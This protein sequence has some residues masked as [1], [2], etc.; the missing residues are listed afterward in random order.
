MAILRVQPASSF[1]SEPFGVVVIIIGV[2]GVV[3]DVVGVIV[4]GVVDAALLVAVF[5]TA[6]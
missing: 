2:G 6:P 5:G 3:V 1:L 4:A